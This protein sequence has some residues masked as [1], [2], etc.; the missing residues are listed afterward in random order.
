VIENNFYNILGFLNIANYCNQTRSLGPG[1]RSV[2]WVQGCL[3][4]CVNCYSPDWIPQKE[5]LL[6]TPE[7][8]AELLNPLENI[9]GITISGGEPM[10]Q[11]D[12][13]IQFIRIMKKMKRELNFILYTGFQ[14]AMIDRCNNDP[15]REI[16]DYIDVLID[17]V[18]IDDLNN[19]LGIRGSTNQTVWHLSNRLISHD[20]TGNERSVEI[21]I[22]RGA[23]HFIGVPDKKIRNL[24]RELE[25]KYVR[26]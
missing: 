6:I 14:K 23:I 5:A 20:F 2:V 4:N 22:K 8:L 10:L 13:L 9:D 18:Y 16:L 15:K 21:Q 11:A 12:R 7:K 1:L 19:N 3:L 24:S 17:G 25:K 26:P